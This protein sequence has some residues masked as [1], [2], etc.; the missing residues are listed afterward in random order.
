MLMIEW[1]INQLLFA[2]EFSGEFGGEIVNVGIAWKTD[3]QSKSNE[4]HKR[5]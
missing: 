1:K 4:I 2:D 3:S 5:G